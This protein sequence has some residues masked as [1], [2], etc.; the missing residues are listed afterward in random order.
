ML[1]RVS[2]H[3][4][5][6]WDREAATFDDQPD[7]GLQDPQVRRTWEE[8]LLPLVGRPPRSVVDLGCGTGTLTLLLAGA[9]HHVHGVDFSAE[10]LALARA[11][12]ERM[13]LTAT[14]TLG[15]AAEPPLPEAAFDVVV[16][17]HV[18]W[19]MPDP[20][21]AIAAWTRLLTPSGLLLLV[22]GHWH[23]GAGLTADACRDLV[24]PHRQHVEIRPLT[25]PALWG[26][27]I[28]DERYL[29]ISRR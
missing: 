29:L 27:Q 19:A 5:G 12:A 28:R 22:E 13:Q 11:K 16:S 15:N 25:D 8:L 18:L 2:D 17:R 4:N 23:T 6:A 10:M 3:I 24:L 21:A 9:G 7:H 14:F 20:S 26:G 1:G